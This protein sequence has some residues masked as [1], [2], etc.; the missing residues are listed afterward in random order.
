MIDTALGAR[1]HA[2]RHAAPLH[3]PAAGS[4]TP[5][6]GSAPT[7][8]DASPR[9]VERACTIL[10]GVEWVCTI[11]EPNVARGQPRCAPARRRGRGLPVRRA[12]RPRDRRGAHRRPPRRGTDR[13][14]A[15]GAKVGWT[16]A[17]Q[18]LVAA[19][20]AEAKHAEV[21][22]SGRTCSWSL[23]ATTTSSASSRTRASSSTRTGSS[24]T[25][26]HPD[27]TLI[28][29][30]YRPDALGIAVRHTRDV[31]GDVPIIVTE[32]GI[33]TADDDT[34][35]R[36]HDRGAGAP[37]APPSTTASTSAATS[38]GACS[39]TSSGA[40]GSPPSASSRS[41]A[42]VRAHPKPSLAWLG[43]IA[44]RNAL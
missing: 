20:G 42:N 32:N 31:V 13:A 8:S 29:W 27:N 34:P 24:P 28:G 12:A 5:A 25:R 41:T 33:A 44:R 23:L 1:P 22:H 17:N 3:P 19:P 36:V 39:T 4:A 35:D 37:A 6:A 9:Y 26:E 10:D 14:D 2:G 11:N 7:R 30:A 40:A 21:Q 18:A 16:V 38:T 15:T 43:K